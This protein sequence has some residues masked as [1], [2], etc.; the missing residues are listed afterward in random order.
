MGTDQR[1]LKCLTEDLAGKRQD[2]IDRFSRR[3]AVFSDHPKTIST[4]E[5]RMKT[6]LWKFLDEA[7]ESGI[8]TIFPRKLLWAL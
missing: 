5:I 1:V 3:I 6:L 2:V 7:I 8:W 4:G